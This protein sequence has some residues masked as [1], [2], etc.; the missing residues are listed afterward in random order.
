MSEPTPASWTMPSLLRK[1]SAIRSADVITMP[2]KLDALAVRVLNAKAELRAAQDVL[3]SKELALDAAQVDVVAAKE[4]LRG[5]QRQLYHEVDSLGCF[6]DDTP[7]L[8]ES[9]NG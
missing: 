4:A 1:A 7:P 8:P 3:A 9:E 5:L 2:P 6:D